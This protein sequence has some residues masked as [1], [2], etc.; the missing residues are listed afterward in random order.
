[1]WVEVPGFNPGKYFS[2]LLC[3]FFSKTRNTELRNKQKDVGARYGGP[4]F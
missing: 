2:I 4:R 3:I 1:M